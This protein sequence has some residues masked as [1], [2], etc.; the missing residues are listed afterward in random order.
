[1][2][3]YE[4]PGL[5]YERLDRARRPLPALRMDVTGFV[6]M[7][8]RG[9]LDRPVPVES[10]RQFETRFGGFIGG[11]FLAYALKGFFDNGG[12]RA[13]IVRIASREPDTGAAAAS[14]PLPPLWRI[15]A[16]SSGSWGNGLS[17]AIAPGRRVETRGSVDTA[18]RLSCPVASTAGFTRDSLV[19]ITQVG[20][21]SF[22]RVCALIDETARRLW[23]AHPDPRLRRLADAALPTLDPG[24]PLVIESLSYT[25]T[26]RE[27]GRVV[28]VFANL[29]LVRGHSRYA[30][31]VLRPLDVEGQ[32]APR[33]SGYMLDA[34]RAPPPPVPT[35]VVW[36]PEDPEAELP[37]IPPPLP[38]D[39]LFRDL[40]GGRGGL[41]GLTV[42]DF[43][44][45]PFGSEARGL[46]ALERIGEIGLL[47]IPD[48]VVRPVL[49]P[50]IEAVPPPQVDP[51]A[52]CPQPAA[53]APLRPPPPSELPPLFGDE[54]VFRVQQALVEHC[55]RRRDCMAL[56]DP[57]V[58]TIVDPRLGTA[59]IEAWRQRFDSRY[60]TLY[61]PWLLV[62]DPLGTGLTRAVPPSGH[63][64]GQYALA[65]RLEGVHRAAANRPLAWAEAPSQPV[66]AATHGL[67]NTAGIDV[68]RVEPGRGLQILGARTLSSDPDGRLVPV[69]RVLMLILRSVDR[70]LRWAA[71]EPNDHTTRSNLVLTLDGFLR[72]LWQ[73]GAL[74]G[75]TAEA[76]FAIRCDEGNNPPTERALGKLLCELAVA[77]AVPFEY[78]VLQ[79]GRIGE[80]L[81]VEERAALVRAEAA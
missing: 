7:A 60:A 39:G 81:E 18:D 46:Q 27:R 41:A 51:C 13:W 15:E 79:V 32:P 72:G 29:S 53:V 68:I 4:T 65:D 9:P 66:D 5:Y 35:P 33:L 12:S 20:M 56:L 73:Q 6:G 3:T 59:P 47:A 45:E 75:P 78:V 67:L 37:P 1:M 34:E 36:L 80:Q 49:P 71:F 17:V 31:D 63:V 24:L 16:S 23:W 2:P 52:P 55:E 76:A 43:I 8:E 25:L 28:A 58:S 14:L 11:G 38:A 70:G 69:R 26:V 40:A 62:V 42:R 21:P 44:G 22:Q 64:A 74:V 30:L 10:F 77:P 50:E 54:Q 61:F 48:I 19:Q 57:P